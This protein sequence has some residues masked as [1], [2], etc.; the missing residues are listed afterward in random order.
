MSPSSSRRAEGMMRLNLVEMSR[1]YIGLLRGRNS[2]VVPA[3]TV[4]TAAFENTCV[5]YFTKA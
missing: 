3:R 1:M 5:P 4:T 2:L